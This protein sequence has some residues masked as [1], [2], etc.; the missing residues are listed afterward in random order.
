MALP[1]EPVSPASPTPVVKTCAPISPGASP[2]GTPK[3]KRRWTQTHK[4]TSRAFFVALVLFVALV[5]VALHRQVYDQV[6]H[7]PLAP[8]LNGWLEANLKNEEN[9]ASNNRTEDTNATLSENIQAGQ[10][11]KYAYAYLVGGC[12]PEKPSYRYYIYD[13][14]INTVMQRKEGST[15]DIVVMVQMKYDSEYEKLPE[16]DQRLLDAMNIKV[17]YI[18]K[19]K[20]ESFYRLMHDKF[21]I[22]RMTQYK[23]I[24]FLD[25]DG[26]LFSFC[27]LHVSCH[28]EPFINMRSIFSFLRVRH[29]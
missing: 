15:A 29:Q 22:L 16:E 5:P 7:D 14:M 19:A 4:T 26:M 23:R 24:M 3:K 13:I 1:V 20:D 17:V 6:A 25:G 2:F 11:A 28:V 9:T 8:F 21:L 27:W 10:P 18:P 12:K